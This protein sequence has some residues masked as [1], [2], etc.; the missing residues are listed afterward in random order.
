[1]GRTLSDISPTLPRSLGAAPWR[2]AEG[3]GLDQEHPPLLKGGLGDGASRSWVT[4]E[5]G[6]TGGPGF[7]RWE[8]GGALGVSAP[9]GWGTRGRRSLGQEGGSGGRW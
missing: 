6:V 1:M 5:L 8:S 4:A 2:L 9:E 3:W 7:T